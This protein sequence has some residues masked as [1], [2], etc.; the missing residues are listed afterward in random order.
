MIE[1]G[2]VRITD[3]KESYLLELGFQKA[4][5]SQKSHVLFGAG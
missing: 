4:G 3:T 2:L 1:I 5:L